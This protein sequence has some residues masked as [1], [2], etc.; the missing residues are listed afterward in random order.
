MTPEKPV[1]AGRILGFT[2]KVPSPMLLP[3]YKALDVVPGNRE[4]L[5]KRLRERMANLT[6]DVTNSGQFHHERTNTWYTLDD[7]GFKYDTGL[8]FSEEDVLKLHP[9]PTCILD[10]GLEF[11]IRNKSPYL[12][13]DYLHVDDEKTGEKYMTERMSRELEGIVHLSTHDAAFKEMGAR[14]QIP[15]SK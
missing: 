14:K 1:T 6:W 5:F 2:H 4:E 9:K 15:K 13:A 3:F 11:W 12:I 10:N 7:I 8:G